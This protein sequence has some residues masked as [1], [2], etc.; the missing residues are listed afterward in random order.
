V[1]LTYRERS[2]YTN[3]T[4]GT[5][6]AEGFAIQNR[7]IRDKIA[8]GAYPDVVAL[9][10]NAYT[11]NHDDWFTSDGIHLTIRGSYGV[12]DYIS[13]AVASLH[14]EPCPAPWTVGGA[15]EAPCSWPDDRIGVVDPLAV[16]AGNPN[17]IHCYQVGDDRH[18]ECK[19]D[20][21]LAH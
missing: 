9:D 13:R 20:P 8:S 12:A 21:K 3:P 10:W 5:S 11:A 16:Y 15:I 6:Q 7:I 4:G 14:G 17:D 19:V 18:V 2:T 1:W